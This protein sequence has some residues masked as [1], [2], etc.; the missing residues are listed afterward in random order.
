MTQYILIF[1]FIGPSCIIISYLFNGFLINSR[2]L[3][4]SIFQSKFSIVLYP[5]DMIFSLNSLE[6]QLVIAH[7]LQLNLDKVE[8]LIKKLILH[9]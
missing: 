1:W 4:N 7:V 9:L 6:V 5:L 8:T 3:F 2:I